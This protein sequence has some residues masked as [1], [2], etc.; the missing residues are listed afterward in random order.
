MWITQ[1]ID[2]NS[3]NWVIGQWQAI[4]IYILNVTMKKTDL[5][6]YFF[7]RIVKTIHGNGNISAIQWDHPYPLIIKLANG[8]DRYSLSEITLL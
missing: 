1:I 7:G 8:F 6:E 2:N 4:C 5:S 3:L